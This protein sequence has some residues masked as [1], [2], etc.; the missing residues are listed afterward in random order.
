MLQYIQ[1]IEEQVKTYGGSQPSAKGVKTQPREIALATVV[2]PQE[3]ET[4]LR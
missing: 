2:P 4:D 1:E 3:Q